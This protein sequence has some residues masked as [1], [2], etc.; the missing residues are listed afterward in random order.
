MPIGIKDLRASFV[1]VALANGKTET[2]VTDRT[3]HK[4]SE[5]VARY[6]RKA[7][8]AAELDLG[9][10]K[11][12][13]ELLFGTRRNP[14]KESSDDDRPSG[15]EHENQSRAGRVPQAVRTRSWPH[16]RPGLSAQIPQ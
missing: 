12:L 13:D 3:G 6:R 7:R 2:W 1:T 16:P 14:E 9:T 4:S 8:A 10:Y 11:P 5:M 15:A